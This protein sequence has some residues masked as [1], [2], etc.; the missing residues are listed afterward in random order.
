M[1]AGWHRLRR[2]HACLGTLVDQGA[3]VKDYLVTVKVR[4]NNILRAIKA[5]G[6]E[7][8]GKW[9]SENGLSYQLVNDL[10][11]MTASPLLADGSLRTM[12]EKL[13]EAV[14]CLPEDLWSSE[15]LYP[16]ETNI[17]SIEMDHSQVVA[18]IH[19]HKTHYLIDETCGQLSKHMDIALSS[20]AKNEET[21]L[22]MRNYEDMTLLEI[23]KH[24][25]LSR[26]RVR[27]IEA[28]A[29]RKLRHPSISTVLGQHLEGIDGEQSIKQ[30]E[31]RKQT[32]GETL[33]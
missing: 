27:Q 13:C 6:G 25:R 14:N 30:Y 22:R 26:E 21:V 33:L 23:A 4:N 9:C 20:L 18:L 1:L 2:G 31:R 17:S 3:A 8:G 29:L 10:I 16:L 19:N 24:L 7:P 15:Q 12:A 32:N 11:N 5:A 28:K